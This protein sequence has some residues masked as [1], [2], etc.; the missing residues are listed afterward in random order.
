MIPNLSRSVYVR[1]EQTSHI[2]A[3]APSPSYGSPAS[4]V[5]PSFPFIPGR[6]PGEAHFAFIYVA[7]PRAVTGFQWRRTSKYMPR[8]SL[9][10]VLVTSSKD[11]I[12][13]YGDGLVTSIWRAVACVDKQVTQHLKFA[14][15]H[16]PTRVWWT[17]RRI[18]PLVSSEYGRK[19][20]CPRTMFR[21]LRRLPLHWRIPRDGEC[22]VIISTNTKEKWWP[23]SN[24]FETLSTLTRPTISTAIKTRIITAIITISMAPRDCPTRWD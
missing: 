18:K 9:A 3:S 21:P 17:D 1:Y 7:H 20:Y 11:N 2:H 8:G 12:C 10:N 23:N 13:R 16:F 5:T 6:R 4:G 19:R 22:R 15:L 14:I 24:T